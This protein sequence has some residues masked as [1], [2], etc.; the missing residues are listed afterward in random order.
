[1][2]SGGMGVSSSGLV[3]LHSKGVL[4]GAYCLKEL[5]SPGRGSL[6]RVS[7]AQMLKPQK[8]TVYPCSLQRRRAIGDIPTF[9]R[10]Q[11]GLYL[12]GGGGGVCW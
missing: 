10:T 4:T 5:A 1:M 12:Q 3:C 9:S 2:R 7:K 6:P 8:H 11:H